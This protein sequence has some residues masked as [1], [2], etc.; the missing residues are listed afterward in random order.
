MVYKFRLLSDEVKDFIRD[1]EI[2]SDQ[3]FFDFHRLIQ[4]DLGYDSSQIASFFTT[5]KA[6]EKEKEFTLF[7]MTDEE[8][9]LTIPMDRAVLINYILDPRQRLIYVFDIFNERS[10][11]IELT[12]TQDAI[13]YSDY[14]AVTF[15]KGNPPQQILFS[16]NKNGS[17]SDSEIVEMDFT[18]EY[19]QTYSTEFPI[20][21]DEYFNEDLPFDDTGENQD[22]E[23]EE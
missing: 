18:E 4:D 12:D 5:N 17:F 1:I 10:F 22:V 16:N 19:D 14:P 15:S 3:T 11:F 7:D 21:P 6:W 23:P 20:E 2:R 9:N 13:R 8:N